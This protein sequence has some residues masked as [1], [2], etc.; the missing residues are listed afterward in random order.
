M[1]VEML[2]TEERQLDSSIADLHDT[3]K[4]KIASIGASAPDVENPRSLLAHI[5]A[6]MTQ[7]RG[8]IRHLELLAEEQET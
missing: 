3:I 2:N 1:S 5:Q 6:Y 8:N 7:L 4:K